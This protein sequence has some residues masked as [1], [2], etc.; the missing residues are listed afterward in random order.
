MNYPLGSRFLLIWR[1]LWQ[2]HRRCSPIRA[3][4]FV[5]KRKKQLAEKINHICRVLFAD[6]TV[7]KTVAGM[8]TKTA[9]AC[10][11]QLGNEMTGVA[12]EIEQAQNQG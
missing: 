2:N 7:R 3:I 1:F 5:E 11:T 4:C 10:A 6:G 9:S 8:N 12:A